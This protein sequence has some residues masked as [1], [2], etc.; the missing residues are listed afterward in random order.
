MA[1]SPIVDNGAVD[2]GDKGKFV[3]NGKT[4]ESKAD[5]K[6]HTANGSEPDAT[7]HAEHPWLPKAEYQAKMATANSIAG[8]K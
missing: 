2:T 6:Y 5:A 3:Q 1:D 8:A 7:W 4:Y